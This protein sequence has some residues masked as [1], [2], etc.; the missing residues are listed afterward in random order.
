VPLLL[1]F[2]CKLLAH[3]FER[4]LGA[5]RLLRGRF[6][7]LPLSFAQKLLAHL[8]KL[9]L[10]SLHLLR[11]EELLV[12]RLE[13]SADADHEIVHVRLLILAIAS[14]QVHLVDGAIAVE[15]AHVRSVSATAHV[16]HYPRQAVHDA[17]DRRMSRSGRFLSL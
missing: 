1:A 7:R 14:D 11:A 16:T 2:A 15:K 12:G 17:T 8:V 4:R 13:H 10:G 3:L 6:L 5:L 9:Y